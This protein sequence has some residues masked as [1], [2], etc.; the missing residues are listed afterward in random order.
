MSALT[1]FILKSCHVAPANRVPLVEFIAAFRSSLP[2]RI[3][4][5]WSRGRITA[6]LAS[7]GFAIGVDDDRRQ[8]V[9]GLTLAGAWKTVDGRMA[10]APSRV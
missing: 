7:L 9:A 6:D 2:A 10:F 1:T 4:D 5:S 8:H 3:K